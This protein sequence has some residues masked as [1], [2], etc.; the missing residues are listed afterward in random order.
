MK[1]TKG[2]EL[3]QRQIASLKIENEQDALMY[4]IWSQ[5]PWMIDVYTGSPGDSKYREIISWCKEQFGLDAWPIH[6]RPGDWYI[7]GATIHGWAWMGFR[8][9]EMMEQFC[10]A[11]GCD[12]VR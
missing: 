7:G 5:F 1:K 9:K 6:G 8:T 11:W 12:N 4:E 10:K 3:Y 2:T